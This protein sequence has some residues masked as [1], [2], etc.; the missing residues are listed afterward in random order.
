[1]V[2]A[3]VVALADQHEVGRAE[4][5]EQ[6]RLVDEALA[7]D[8]ADPAGERVLGAELVLPRAARATGGEQRRRRRRQRGRGAAVR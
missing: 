5:G 4:I 3:I 1:M 7:R 8:V 2:V 6:R